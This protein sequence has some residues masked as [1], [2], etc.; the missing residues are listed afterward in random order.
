MIHLHFGGSLSKKG[1]LTS[2]PAQGKLFKLQKRY[3]T[4]I[5]LENAGFGTGA[6]AAMLCISTERVK[7]YKR[8]P[9]YLAARVRITHGIIL[10]H[11]GSLALI[12]EQ[13]R[14]ILT[15]MLPTALQA[16]AE[17]ITRPAGTLAERKLQTSLA[18]EVLDRE[19][20]LA[21]VSRTEVKPVDSFDFEHADRASS[22]V[23]AALKGVAI[24]RVST[25]HTVESVRANAEF[26]ASRTLSAE[27][28]QAALDTLEAMPSASGAVN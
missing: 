2:R 14:E 26:S 4:I 28:Q 8:T 6:I 19:G 1:N 20:T 23:I 15:Q 3:E 7:F 11:T 27:E 10:D 9:D 13:R 16:I 24:E 22:D 17:A 25:I 5:R 12:K 21:K 18:L